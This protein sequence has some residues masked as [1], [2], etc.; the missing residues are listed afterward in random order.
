MR[1]RSFHLPLQ[2]RNRELIDRRQ[3]DRRLL[4]LQ[5]SGLNQGLRG[6]GMKQLRHAIPDHPNRKGQGGENREPGTEESWLHKDKTRWYNC[7][8]LLDEI[9]PR[10]LHLADVHLGYNKY[11]NAER[12]LDFFYALKDVLELYAIG[13]QVDFVLIAGDLF[14]HRNILPAT[15]NQAQICLDL[16]READIPVLAIEGNHDY[17]PYGA[18][19][20]WLRYLAGW[21]RLILL[22]P[23]EADQLHPWSP[24]TRR[25]GYLDLDCG[26]RV[27]GS[28]WYRAAAAQMIQ[29]LAVSVAQLP[30]GPAHT[31]MM[32][33]HGLEGQI[34]R[35]SGALKYQELLPL[36]EAGVDYLALGH[37]HKSY[38]EQNWIFN[39][40][41][42]EANSIA[43]GQDQIERGVYLVEMTEQGIQAELKKAYYQRPIVRMQLEA[44]KDQTR[45]DLRQ[46]AIDLVQQVAAQGKLRD[47]I[48]ELRIYGQV[49]FNR[50]DLNVREL[51]S[52]LHRVSEAL[53]FLLKYDVAGTRYDTPLGIRHEDDLPTRWEIER[54][55]FQ[56]LLAGHPDYQAQLD[57]VVTAT[58]QL[59]EAILAKQADLRRN[60]EMA[61]TELYELLGALTRS[62]ESQPAAAQSE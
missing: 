47:A 6:L 50:L 62:P 17:E 2:V 52:Q 24:E 20:S 16:L 39:P 37:I 22:E 44:S 3:S 23:D 21:E 19:S 53:I 35:Y 4:G 32:F 54:V 7:I 1:D 46:A 48:G 49:G 57:Q 29:K 40:G 58:I 14:E 10:F 51:R 30:K 33:H 60:E 61:V 55:V 38:S 26:V 12:T 45:E 9:M 18:K 27:I 5:A 59:K 15:L 11:D 28:R 34:A 31:V 25:G 13:P 43:E 56:D 41:A 8:N 36:K 42:V